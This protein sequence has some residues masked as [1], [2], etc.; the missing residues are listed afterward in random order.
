MGGGILNFVQIKDYWIKRFVR[1]VLPSWVF[2]TFYFVIDYLIGTDVNPAKVVMCYS[3][4]TSWY[5]WIIRILVVMALIAPFLLLYTKKLSNKSLLLIL[6]VLL[7]VSEILSNM[8]D[9]Y[10]FMIIVMFIPYVVYYCI[11]IN[12][13]RFSD[14]K[15]LT[16]GI[17]FLAFYVIIALLLYYSN[18][19][20]I[21]TQSFKYPPR[22]Y[23]TSYALGVSAFLYVFREKLVIFLKMAH[24]LRFATFVGSHTFWIYLWHIPIVEYMNNHYDDTLT[25]FITVYLSAVMISL[26]QENMIELAVNRIKSPM[27]SKN[28]KNIFI[29]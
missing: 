16:A 8:S 21:P 12:I 5:F 20:Y 6:S 11:G 19:E 7:S 15:I 13:T 18:D 23:Y 27:L 17:F 24:L 26:I 1:L 10:W 22:F 28:I 9:N 14:N 25:T 29:G 3:F 4:T 2:L